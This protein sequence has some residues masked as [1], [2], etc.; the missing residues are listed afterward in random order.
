MKELS[1]HI[2]DTLQNAVEAGASAIRLQ[3]NE[4]LDADE[5]TIEISD[6]GRG[7]SKEMVK[8]VLD[9]F[10]TT[11]RHRKVGLGLALF[12]DAAVRCDGKLDI[13]SER[14]IGTRI[15]AVF[16]H[17]HIDRAP[18]GDMPG[19]IMP[20]LLSSRK[21]DLA[22]THKSGSG[23]FDFDSASIRQELG[24][25]PLSNPKVA[26]WLFQCLTEGESSLRDRRAGQPPDLSTQPS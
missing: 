5:L 3:I 23:K 2:L 12:A 7:M 4:D 9:P 10:V 26:A 6:N 1:L 8:R 24:E 14:G 21:V 22:Y 18:L 11:R 19:A 16:R 25:V 20:I 17:S 13:R 15:T